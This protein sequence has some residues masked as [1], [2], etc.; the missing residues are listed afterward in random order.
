MIY[1]KF[2]VNTMQDKV[3]FNMNNY[4]I[5]KE[6]MREKAIEWQHDFGNHNYSYQELNEYGNYFKNF[7]K[8][9]Q[10]FGY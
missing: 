1:K 9:S 4:Q 2:K 8:G 5:Y 3:G 10:A 7:Y 6:K